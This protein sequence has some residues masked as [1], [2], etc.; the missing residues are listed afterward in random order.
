[1]TVN[2]SGAEEFKS[3]PVESAFGFIKNL[4]PL[5]SAIGMM[6]KW[7]IGFRL[8]L[9]WECHDCHEGVIIPSSYK[10]IHG[11]IVKIYPENL[12]PNTKVMR[13]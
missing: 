1:M 5:R 7:N 2:T 6:E 3:Q 10:N 4:A 11:E 12:D 8:P 9:V 13:F